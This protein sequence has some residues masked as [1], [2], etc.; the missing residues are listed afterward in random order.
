MVF[1]AVTKL[2]SGFSQCLK[3]ANRFSSVLCLLRNK[4]DWIRLQQ[5]KVI[6]WNKLV[7][8]VTDY[9]RQNPPVTRNRRC[10]V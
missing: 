5:E 3:Q 4:H 10:V 6:S 7:L 2:L 1:K 9:A 8:P